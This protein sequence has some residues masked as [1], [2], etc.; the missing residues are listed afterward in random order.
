VIGLTPLKESVPYVIRVDN[1]TGI[2][3]VAKALTDN[4]TNYE[5]VINKYFLQWYLRYREGYSR[6]L[7]SEY[8]TNVGLMSGAQE[9][10]K[11]AEWFDPRNPDSPLSLYGEHGKVTIQI[12]GVTFIKPNIALIRYSKEIEGLG[13][14]ENA[15]PTHWT[16]TI[17]FRYIK[18]PIGEKERAINPLGFQVTE[19]RT[20][21]DSDTSFK[22]KA[23]PAV[24]A[25]ETP[26]SDVTGF[27]PVEAATPPAVDMAVPVVESTEP[28]S[29]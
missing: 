25:P 23:K 11:Y 17:T 1:T 13:T 20:D 2:V 7:A 19:Y 10:K 5:E 27:P 3:D 21:P 24:E 15:R 16:A 12:K 9:Q 26:D 14:G 4:R 8:Y 22:G 29:N 28:T 6:G 18:A